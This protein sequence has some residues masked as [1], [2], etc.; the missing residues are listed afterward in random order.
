MTRSLVA[1]VAVLVVACGIALP[2]KAGLA[3]CIG[4]VSPNP[5]NVGVEVCLPWQM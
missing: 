2:A 4:V 5:N 3:E 1:T